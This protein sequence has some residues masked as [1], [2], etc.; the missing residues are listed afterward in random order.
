MHSRLNDI[1]QQLAKKY[2]MQGPFLEVGVGIKEAAI[3]SGS[4]FQGKPERF[5]TNLSDKEIIDE[6]DDAKIEFI[7]CNSNNM[8]DNFAD[9]QFKTVLSNAVIEHDKYFWRSLDEMKRVLAPG[10]IL[11]VGAPGYIARKHVKNEMFTSGF[12]KATVTYDVHSVPD[13]W[14]FSRMAF[15]EVICEG[16]DILETFIFGRVP[17]LVAVARKPLTGLHA[18]VPQGD[19]SQQ[20]QLAVREEEI[21]EL[22]DEDDI[23]GFSQI[24]LER[25]PAKLAKQQARKEA[26]LQNR[27][28]RIAG[29]TPKARK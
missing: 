19:K 8:K 16:L 15:R 24:V 29:K 1:Y 2:E 21:L 17:I 22:Q 5:A 18:P 7:R 13:Y 9:G 12:K 4:Y 10:G 14:R 23:E 20:R 27:E 28:A 3:L 6:Q 26:R 25:D 11:A